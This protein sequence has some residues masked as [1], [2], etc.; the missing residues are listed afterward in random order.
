MILSMDLLGGA[1]ALKIQVLKNQPYSRIELHK[2]MRQGA[3]SYAVLDT[4]LAG[5]G[6]LKRKDV[7]DVLGVST[8][9]LDRQ[10]TA[11]ERSM[12]ADLASRTWMLA[13]TMAKA[14]EVFGGVQQAEA[15]MDKPAMGLDGC[16]PIEMLQT[17]QGVEV[18]NDFL[19]RLEYGVYS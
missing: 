12:P 2:A 7:A 13:E 14:S 8:R 9:T 15:W 1:K 6:A 5:L 11:P 3:F 18:V 19:T 4:L 17:L 10:R 16:R